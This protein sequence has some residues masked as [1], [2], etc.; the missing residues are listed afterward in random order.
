MDLIVRPQVKKIGKLRIERKPGEDLGD[1]DVLVADRA[2]RRLLGVEAKDLA[3]ART[4]AELNNELAETFLSHD[5]KQAAI[6][7]HLERIAWLREHLAEVLDWLGLGDEDTA[8]WTV[9]GLMVLDIELMSPYLIDP[10]LPVIT[11]RDLREELGP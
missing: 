9:D 7:R 11:Y 6:D 3:V 5:G 1:I 8:A 2:Q 4:P 10:P